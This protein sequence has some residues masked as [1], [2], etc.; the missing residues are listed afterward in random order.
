MTEDHSENGVVWGLLGSADTVRVATFEFAFKMGDQV[1]L[2][3]DGLTNHVKEEKILQTL[4]KKKTTGSKCS[5]LL[6]IAN[7]SG[8]RDNISLVLAQII[9]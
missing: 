5:E 2:C 1:L 6:R 7:N 4:L 9:R 3:T 8:G